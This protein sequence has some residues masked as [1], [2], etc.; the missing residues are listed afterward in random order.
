MKTEDLQLISTLGQALYANPAQAQARS[1]ETVAAMSTLAG[2]PG[3]EFLERALGLMLHQAERDGLR[4]SV[5]GISS[6]FF[7]LSAKERFVLFLLH[8]GRASYRRVARLL[9]ITSEDVQAIAWQARVQIASSPDVRMTAPH[10]S[11][12]SKLKQSCPEYDPAKPWMQKFIDDEMGTPELSFLQNH[13]AVC[14]DCQRALNSTREFYYAVEKWVPLSVVTANTEELGA[15]L[16]RALRRGQIE[17]GQLPSDLRFFEAVGLFIRKR[18]NLIW[19]GLLGLLLF[20]LAFAKSRV[21]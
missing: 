16:K 15:T 19:L 21:S 3:D 7:R 9:S 1:L 2:G 11:G 8:S 18:E 12:S 14:P 6:P 5:S 20:A 4:S 13:T 17:A 10:P